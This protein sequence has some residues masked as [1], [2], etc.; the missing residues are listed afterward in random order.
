MASN[1][2]IAR[3]ITDGLAATFWDGANS[4]HRGV[5]PPRLGVTK[6]IRPRPSRTHVESPTGCQSIGMLTFENHRHS[7]QD[8]QKIQP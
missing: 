7:L 4:A 1:C 2:A 5:A 8:D 3:T 6:G